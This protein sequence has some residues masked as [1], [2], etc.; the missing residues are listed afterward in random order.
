[1]GKSVKEGVMPREII[2]QPEPRTVRLVNAAGT[3]MPEELPPG[4]EDSN[5][6][7]GLGWNKA[8][9]VQLHLM[10]E[11]WESTAEWHI[12]DLG[13]GDINALIRGLRKARDAAYGRDE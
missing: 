7:V 11:G 3:P 12:V 9:W 10:R 1:M 5:F 6:G 2:V 8:G 4:A 13:R